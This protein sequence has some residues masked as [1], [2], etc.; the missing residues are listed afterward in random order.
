MKNIERFERMESWT[1]E[2]SLNALNQTAALVDFLRENQGNIN[3]HIYDETIGYIHS[4]LIDNCKVYSLIFDKEI[5]VNSKR[6]FM[7]GKEGLEETLFELGIRENTVLRTKIHE[8]EN[9]I[10][11]VTDLIKGDRTN[12]TLIHE[13][14]SGYKPRYTKISMQIEK[15]E[16]CIDDV[17][18]GTREWVDFVL[19]AKTII[20]YLQKCL[21][22]LIE[23]QKNIQNG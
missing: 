20:P 21:D 11:K 17:T 6:I 22:E 7:F 9:V 1:N 23:K 19:V 15:L 12:R 8:L 5:D 4:I 3:S 13:V 2:K 14:L 16:E 18:M 10:S